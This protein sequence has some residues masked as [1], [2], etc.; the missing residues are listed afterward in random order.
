MDTN[1]I[2]CEKDEDPFINR[3]Q[4]NIYKVGGLISRLEMARNSILSFIE[5]KME[6]A[7]DTFDSV[8]I[9]VAVMEGGGATVIVEDAPVASPVTFNL[10]LENVKSN[11][12]GTGC[13]APAFD[14]VSSRITTM[15]N[16][17]CSHVGLFFLTDGSPS[18]RIPVGDQSVSQVR[19]SEQ[20]PTKQPLTNTYPIQ[21]SAN[22]GSSPP[23][24][25]ELRSSVDLA[26]P[27]P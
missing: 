16:D 15:I 26:S 13:Y 2:V 12:R 5:E 23:T 22:S 25:S 10:V 4:Q 9:S 20:Q 14:L 8:Y 1:D 7:Y 11:K 21:F 6:H 3:I 19:K 18:D 24:L 17:G 27:T